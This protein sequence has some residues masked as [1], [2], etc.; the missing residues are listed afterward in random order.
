M[1]S[2]NFGISNAAYGAKEVKRTG[3]FQ[4]WYRDEDGRQVHAGMH[5]SRP[6]ALEAAKALYDQYI[7]AH[8][9]H[10][11]LANGFLLRRLNQ[12]DLQFINHA[13]QG[14]FH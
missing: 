4:G 10:Y 7:T 9:R 11:Q 6:D 2:D 12:A 1:T 5:S 13:G 8:D 3:R 14:R